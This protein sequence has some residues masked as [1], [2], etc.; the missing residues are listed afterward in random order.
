M[1]CTALFLKDAPSEL[2]YDTFGKSV[3][4]GKTYMYVGRNT[5]EEQR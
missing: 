2:L 3:G 5:K 4:K 1:I